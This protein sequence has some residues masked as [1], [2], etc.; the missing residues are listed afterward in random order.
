[1]ALAAVVGLGAGWVAASRQV[2]EPAHVP[3]PGP[4]VSVPRHKE[5]FQLVLEGKPIAG[6]VGRYFHTGNI[7]FPV[8]PVEPV[9][10]AVAGRVTP[11]RGGLDLQAC[12]RS[13]HV[14]WAGRGKQP[15]I[16]VTGRPGTVTPTPRWPIRAGEFEQP[17]PLDPMAGI[18]LYGGQAVASADWMWQV[19]GIHTDFGQEGLVI[20]GC[21]RPDGTPVQPE[22]AIREYFEASAGGDT[23]RCLALLTEHRR[24]NGWCADRNVV[25]IR[26]L[27]VHEPLTEREAEY[28]QTNPGVFSVRVLPVSYE[29]R[30]QQER[31]VTSGRHTWTYILVREKPDSPW[32]IADWHSFPGARGDQ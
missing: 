27:A 20:R 6:A 19:L 31:S 14:R 11:L 2:D 10:S 4:T 21:L 15:R 12:G 25:S 3:T 9:V 32:Q 17:R 24:R 30:F 5:R 22:Q 16:E 8:F 26:L 28:R 7:L 29:V 13:T 18:W 1:V 23:T